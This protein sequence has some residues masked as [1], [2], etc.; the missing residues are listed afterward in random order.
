NDSHLGK[1]GVLIAV[2][3]TYITL[4]VPELQ[5]NCEIVWCNMEIV[6]HKTVYLSSYYNP[7]TSNEKGYNEYGISIERASQIR[8]AFIILAG[9]F[10]LPGWDWTT[11]EIKMHTQCATN[12]EKNT[13]IL[14]D[15]GMAQLVK[16]QPEDPILLIL[17]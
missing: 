4:S 5:T 6:G 3:D 13:D 14:D 8:N 2:K 7:K 11:K 12:H 16:K 15:N 1:G 10:N 17:L 9:G